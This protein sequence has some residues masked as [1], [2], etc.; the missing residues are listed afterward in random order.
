MDIKFVRLADRLVGTIGCRILSGIERLRRVLPAQSKSTLPQNILVIEISEM[1]SVI[2]AY[3]MLQEIKQRYP[4]SNTYFLMFEKIRESLDVLELIPKE[5]VITLNDRN[6]WSFFQSALAAV[7]KLRRLQIDTVL[8]MELFARISAIFSYLSGATHRV[9]FYRYTMEGLYRGSFLTHKVQ[10]TSSTH[11]AKNQMALLDALEA[12]PSSRPLVKRNYSSLELTLP[13]LTNSRGDDLRIRDKLKKQCATLSSN[14]QIVI[15]N[16][17]GGELSIRAWPLSDYISLTQMLLQEDNLFVGVMG[18]ARERIWY[19]RMVK[20]VSSARFFDFTGMTSSV[21]EVIQLFN[22][23]DVL[24]TADSGPAHFAGLSSIHC[25]VFFGP[26]T[27]TLYR[28]LNSN[29]TTLYAGLSCSPCLTA[30]NHR[31]SPCDGNNVCVQEFKPE[32]VKKLVLQACGTRIWP[33][34]RPVH[35]RA[36]DLVALSTVDGTVVLKTSDG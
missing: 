24:V 31:E 11:I 12:D 3:P 4:Q 36:D 30:Y 23:C 5:N 21:R 9:G 29:H 25:I 13:R 1:G 17:S 14:G 20:E 6:L 35:D 33:A 8:D 2:L 7:W 15:L 19:E 16:P 34:P 18:L 22:C 10:Y 26:E 32:Y 28:P 27:P